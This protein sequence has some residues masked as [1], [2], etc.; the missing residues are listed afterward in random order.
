M[1]EQPSR[2]PAIQHGSPL[3][4]RIV[5]RRALASSVESIDCGQASQTLK[6]LRQDMLAPV[7]TY[8]VPCANT[9]NMP[10]ASPHLPA[11]WLLGPERWAI[12]LVPL[13]G[14]FELAIRRLPTQSSPAGNG[15][16]YGQG[17]RHDVPCQTQLVRVLWSGAELPNQSAEAIREIVDYA[18]RSEFSQKTGRHYL[19]GVCQ[20]LW[21]SPQINHDGR[22][23]RV[24][25]RFTGKT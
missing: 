11:A 7:P 14:A 2:L 9:P 16:P 17:S 8:P 19:R 22:L 15:P 10:P 12:A 23:R 6:A 4:P 3:K 21:Q 25:G 20:Q 18:D 1:G 5:Q 24:T 13:S